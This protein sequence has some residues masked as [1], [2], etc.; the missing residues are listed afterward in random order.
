MSREEPATIAIRLLDAFAAADLDGMR[1]LPADD[2]VA[3]VTNADGGMDATSGGDEYLRRIAAMDV[4]S[5]ELRIE[6]TQPP[7]GGRRPDS[8]RAVSNRR[9]MSAHR[10]L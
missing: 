4:R 3:A 10:S 5:A 6:L 8:T 2:L 1:A 9:P 7:V